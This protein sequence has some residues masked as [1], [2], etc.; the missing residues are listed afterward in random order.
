MAFKNMESMSVLMVSTEYPPMPGGVARY[1]RNL[2]I[3]LKRLGIGV[4]IACNERGEGD[5]SGLDASNKEN[6]NILLNIVEKTRPDLVHVQL[7]HGL[8]GLNFG[9]THKFR[10][11]TNIDQFYK[12]CQLPIITTFHS[13]YPIKQW[14]NLVKSNPLTNGHL[15]NFPTELLSRVLKYWNRAL[16]YRSFNQSNREK[17]LRSAA[18]I[19]FSEYMAKML[20]SDSY[21]VNVIY[22]GAEP[23]LMNQPTKE[24]ARSHYSLPLDGKI[25]L[26][27]GFA[28]HTKGWDI[29][30]G[31]KIP[32][33]WTIIVN[34]SKNFYSKERNLVDPLEMH[35]DSIDD[36]S[37][38]HNNYNINNINGNG[39]NVDDSTD[40]NNNYTSNNNSDCKKLSGQYVSS[41]DSPFPSLSV[42]VWIC[43]L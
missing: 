5:Y 6:S 10:M 20:S 12:K 29:L 11:Q 18:S 15:S 14:I 40:S 9:S 25:A 41:S 39:R 19:V 17:M 1:T 35:G 28:T 26:A 31:M 27:L 36:Y 8:Y 37:N 16:T 38:S 32:D 13:A 4:F 34:H 7:E 24:V 22:H 42:N 2:S 43:G 23:S 30:K 21:K 33:N 3:A